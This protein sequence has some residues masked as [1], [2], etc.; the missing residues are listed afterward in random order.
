MLAMMGAI[1]ESKLRWTPAAIRE[2]RERLGMSQAHFAG[3]LGIHHTS[4]SRLEKGRSRPEP[5]VRKDL[6]RI[7]EDTGIIIPG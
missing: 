3:L 1:A 6:D 4:L 2:L 5:R 7:A